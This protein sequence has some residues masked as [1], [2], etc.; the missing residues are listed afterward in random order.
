MKVFKKL[1]VPTE[2]MI[3]RV[4]PLVSI[5]SLVLLLFWQ[6]SCRQDVDC[7]SPPPSFY[8]QIQK[9]GITYPSQKDTL[10]GFGI[11]YVT[12]QQTKIYIPGI[13]AQENI[14]QSGVLISKSRELNDQEF[15][16]E[17]EGQTFTKLKLET[18]VN[19]TRCNNWPQVSKVY[20]NGILV[21]KNTT[22]V[23]VVT[24]K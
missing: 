20:S 11:Y 18:Y 16:I 9:D 17:I 6:S 24:S 5:L 4:Y 1:H 23:Y 15:V 13:A 7:T 2:V 12:D 14:F 22:S 3:K 8:F 21:D 19:P 10:R